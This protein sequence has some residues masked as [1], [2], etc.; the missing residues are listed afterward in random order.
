MAAVRNVYM[1]IN[2]EYFP[3]PWDPLEKWW[4]VFASFVLSRTKQKMCFQ[5]LNMALKY[6]DNLIFRVDMHQGLIFFNY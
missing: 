6:N 4:L 3:G 5:N 1:I 2:C